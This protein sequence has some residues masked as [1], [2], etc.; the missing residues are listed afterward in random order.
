ML[1]ANR[2]SSK[3]TSS[4]SSTTWTLTGGSRPGES[5]H[6]F[7][8]TRTPFRIGR[9]QDAEL[10][11]ES[12]FISSQHAELV[13]SAG[14]LCIRDSGSTNGT[15]V[16]GRRVTHDT[17]LSEG[18]LIELGDISFRVGRREKNRQVGRDTEPMIDKTCHFVDSGD[19]AAARAL[20][21]M[22]ETRALLPCFQ[23]IHELKTGDV[24]GYEFLARSEVEHVKNPGAMFNTAKSINKEVE[25]SVLCRE[26][27][28]EHSRSL[29]VNVPVFLNTHPSEPLLETLVPQLESLRERYPAR[30]LV[31]E[32]H[33]AAVTEPGLIRQL[34]TRL[35]AIDVGLAFDDFGKGQARI[36]ELICAPSDYIKFDASLIRDL[37]EVS[38]EQFRFFRSIMRGIQDEG[39]KTIAEGVETEDMADVCR[40][41]G[42]DLVQGYLFSRPAIMAF[43]E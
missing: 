42:F 12:G 29:P 1:Q 14:L 7:E 41:I 26:Q 27:A 10:C 31:L 3:A 11:V 30:P 9:R 23:P 39:A 17:L 25:L 19:L 33:E 6:T 4:A 22:M 35:Q 5:T 43:N 13:Q 20:M 21:Q 36:R 15:F 38:K 37:Q 2:L 18:D 16:N 34:R 32:I 28:V 40:E 8:I 24:H